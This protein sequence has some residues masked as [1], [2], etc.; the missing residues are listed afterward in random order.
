M[1][2][3]S[4]QTQSKDPLSVTGTNNSIPLHENT[5]RLKCHW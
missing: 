5:L 4:V 3:S 1:G 2:N